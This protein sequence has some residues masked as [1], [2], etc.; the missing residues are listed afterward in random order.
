MQAY[1]S[2]YMFIY[3]FS[4]SGR[5]YILGTISVATSSAYHYWYWTG[6]VWLCL[7]KVL[8]KLV[9]PF[10]YS[11]LY[12]LTEKILNMSSI[13]QFLGMISCKGVYYSKEKGLYEAK[14]QL[15]RLFFE[16]DIPKAHC[17][18]GEMFCGYF[19]I[20]HKTKKSHK[21]ANLDQTK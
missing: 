3:L 17:E 16:C 14:G 5:T 15:A 13:F 1:C 20:C 9:F 10:T 12:A 2:L 4:A 21:W 7:E 18:T 19:T 8:N 6:Y 11:H